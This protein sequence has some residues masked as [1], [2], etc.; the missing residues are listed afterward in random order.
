MGAHA[1]ATSNVYLLF[2]SPEAAGGHH[3][4]RSFPAPKSRAAGKQ[5]KNS[6]KVG[7]EV[8]RWNRADECNA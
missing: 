4:K 2:M 3:R 7:R 5:A 1:E 8:V 6:P